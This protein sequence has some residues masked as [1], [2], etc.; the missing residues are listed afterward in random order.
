MLWIEVRNEGN[1]TSTNNIFKSLSVREF[2]LMSG[3]LLEQKFRI[4]EPEGVE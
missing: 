2:P 3:K 4:K 1:Y